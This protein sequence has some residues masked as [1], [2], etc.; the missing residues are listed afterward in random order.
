MTRFDAA[1][2]ETR[3]ALYADAIA[4][5]RER[6]SQFL[7]IEVDESSL[8]GNPAVAEHGIPW[9]Q[10]ADDTINLDCTNDEL[11]RLKSLLS[12]FPAF[13]IDE[14]TRPENADGINVRLRATTDPERIAQFLDAAI[15]TVYVLP[16]ATKVWAVEV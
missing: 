5:H 4:A 10:F 16:E 11:E 7:T 2:P 14:L 3:R 15:Q 13:S 6:E 1:D 8:E 9:L 12:D